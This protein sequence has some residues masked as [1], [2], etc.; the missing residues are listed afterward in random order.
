MPILQDWQ[1]QRGD[2][3]RAGTCRYWPSSC[4]A[5]R[6]DPFA[7]YELRR[8][9]QAVDPT[10]YLAQSVLTA[11]ATR[12]FLGTRCCGRGQ[13]GQKP[14]ATLVDRDSAGLATIAYLPRIPV[15]R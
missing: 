7:F 4:R 11:S 2:T 8:D 5:E 9:R 1:V 12:A 3:V 15:H 13:S 6:R 14:T 10:P